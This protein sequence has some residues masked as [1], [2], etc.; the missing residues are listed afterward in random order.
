M[1]KHDVALVLPFLAV[2]LAV[3]PTHAEQSVPTQPPVATKRPHTTEI[4]GYTLK[5][6]YFW[7]ARRVTPKSSNTSRARTRIPKR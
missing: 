7:L 1:K 3:P 2:A 6:D 5:D 4:H